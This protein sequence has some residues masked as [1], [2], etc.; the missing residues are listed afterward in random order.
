[1][2][3]VLLL[4]DSIRMFYQKK[5]GEM[6]GEEYHITAPTENCRFSGYTLNSLRYWIP[7]DY[8]P[9]VIH[10]NNGLWDTAILYAEDGCFTPVDQYVRNLA[11]ILRELK[12]LGAPVIF[13]TTTVGRADKELVRSMPLPTCLHRTDIIHYNYEALSLM[14]Q[15]NVLIDDLFSVIDGRENELISDDLLHPNEKGIEALA[16]SVCASIR[17]ALGETK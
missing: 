7:A 10:W 13:A 16:E 11:S 12:K 2:K 17:A 3:E 1:M 9:D 14:K 6:L 15:E 4:G 5:V 8:H